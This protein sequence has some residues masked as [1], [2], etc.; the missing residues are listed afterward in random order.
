MDEYVHKGIIE[1]W[2]ASKWNDDLIFLAVEIFNELALKK[3][4]L[5]PEVIQWI[6]ER[7]VKNPSSSD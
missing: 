1:A 2:N 7:T 5:K 3:N 4:Q 6:V